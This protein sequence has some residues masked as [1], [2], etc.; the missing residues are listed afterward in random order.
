MSVLEEADKTTCSPSHAT[1]GLSEFEH[2]EQLV[3]GNFLFTTDLFH[4]ALFGGRA[5]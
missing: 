2:L 3:M 5:N 4:D 1:K